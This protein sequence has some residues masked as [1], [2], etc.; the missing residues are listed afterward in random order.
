MLQI[1]AKNV[2]IYTRKCVLKFVEF[3]NGLESGQI[4]PVYLFEG[5]DAY[6][7]ERGLNLIKTKIVSEPSLNLATFEGDVLCN[8]LLASLNAFPFLSEKRLTVVREFYPKADFFKSGFKG[9]LENPNQTSVLAIVNTQTCESL[10]KHE[11]VQVVDCGKQDVSLLIRWIKA[12]C[13]KSN[14]QIDGETAKMLAEYCAL[15]MTRIETETSKLVSYA[16]GGTIDGKTVSEMVAKDTEYKIYELTDYVAKKKFDMALTVIFD[17]QAKGE[18]MQRIMLSI[19]NYYRKLLLA[20]ISGK[21]AGELAIAFGIKE[22]PAKKIK[23]QAGMFKKRALKNAVDALTDTDYKIKSG[24]LDADESAYLTIFK[25][26]T[27]S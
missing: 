3:K 4:F 23:E 2:M 10:K 26:M 12:E 14:V 15:D 11:N 6:F 16:F 20:S 8:E 5:E 18:T 19:Y 13:L 9:Y 22:Y 27:E 24:I 21:S 25:I 7:R 17:L 1:Q